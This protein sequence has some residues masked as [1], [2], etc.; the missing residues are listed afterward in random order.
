MHACDCHCRCPLAF[1]VKTPF[2]LS[3][4][5][6]HAPW[7]FATLFFLESVARGSLAT[8][9]PLHAYAV[10]GDK[11][12]VSLAYTLVAA[13]A[14]ISSFAIPLMIR[15]FSRRWSYTFGVVCLIVSGVLLATDSFS[16]QFGAMFLRTF[17]AAT[18][19]ITLSLYIMDHIHKT[20]LVR[21]EP[22]RYGVSTLAW[23][24]APLAGVYFYQRF[25]VWA[26]SILPTIG[27][28]ILIAVFWYLRINEKGGLRPAI[29]PAHNPLV[30][31]RRFA[32][33]PRLR[34]AWLIAF[35]RSAF[36]VT[37]FIYVPILML[38]GGLSA[39][40]GGIAVAA[41]NAML[42]NNL[43]ATGWAQRHSVRTMITIALAGGSILVFA[44]GLAGVSQPF[45]AG[46]MMTCAAFFV[47]ML[48]GLGPVAFLRAVR[49]HERAQMTTVYRTYLDASEL[50]P[51]FV[52][53]FAFMALGFSGAFY[54]LALL[55]LATAWI[56]WTYL[57]KGM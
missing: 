37:F 8:V 2:V 26:A 4:E 24:V 16:G 57:P 18:L 21:S 31:I 42:L 27:A 17:G 14:L 39:Y 12:S 36:W 10:F 49:P 48:D 15:Q 53:F 6:G 25:G 9:M 46:V 45:V 51:P 30:S 28:C 33:Q 54:A 43:L 52:Y 34:L 3:V 40:A 23:M 55:L 56:T 13:L 20:Q 19:N 1:H 41:G 32:S 5:P 35:A 38:E 44:C 22:L 11:G 50:L 7:A 47:S 29:S